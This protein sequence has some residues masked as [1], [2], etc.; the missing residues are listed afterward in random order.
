MDFL[1]KVYK[2]AACKSNHICGQYNANSLIIVRLELAAKV[3]WFWRKQ[4]NVST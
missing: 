4:L 2:C 3:F 1:D